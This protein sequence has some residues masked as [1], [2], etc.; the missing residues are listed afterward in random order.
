MNWYAV[1]TQ[2]K[3]SFYRRMNQ[4]YLMRI[5]ELLCYNQFQLFDALKNKLECVGKLALLLHHG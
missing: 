4:N 5:A 3:K 1:R 2:S